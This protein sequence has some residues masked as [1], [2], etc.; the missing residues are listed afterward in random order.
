MRLGARP[1]HALWASLFLLLLSGAYALEMPVL[2]V[3]YLGTAFMLVL[4]RLDL[5]RSAS[6]PERVLMGLF[7]LT[8]AV[9]LPLAAVRSVTAV[10][11]AAEALL[12][13]GAAFVLT[14]QPE[15]YLVASRI[16]LLTVQVGVF[17]FLCLHGWDN[18]PLENM[19]G[20]QSSNG[21]TSYMIILQ[22]NYSAFN[23]IV[24]RRASTV[25]SLLTLVVCIVG[26]GRGSIL[27]SMGIVVINLL[28]F[29]TLRSM[30]GALWRALAG[31]L[32]VGA[33]G[34]LYSDDIV[35]FLEANTKL[36]SGLFDSARERIL[37]DYAGKI[38]AV[39]FV[40]GADYDGTSIPSEFRGNP[41]NSYIRAHHIFGVFYL[42]ALSLFP[43][44]IFWTRKAWPVKLY[45]SAVLALVL[46]RAST[47]PLLFPSLFDFYFFA[48]FFGLSAPAFA[49]D[50]AVPAGSP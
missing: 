1:D 38:D 13:M 33:V 31:L 9:C 16:S 41:H 11:H 37:I 32:I 20:E 15:R 10:F 29:L 49:A 19:I 39:T 48:L 43:L 50:T 34:M 35:F 45:C 23:F 25:T 3:L 8:L 26:Y 17:A 7:M 46:F 6:N 14:R 28:S 47:E 12:A 44:A 21:I 36:G 2:V 42:L 27:A 22:A 40:T 24:R 18:F 30:S 4:W 5:F